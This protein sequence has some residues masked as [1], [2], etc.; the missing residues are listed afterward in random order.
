MMKQFFSLFTLFM[1]LSL[2]FAQGQVVI[3]EVQY[4]GTDQIEL[5]NTGSSMVDVSNW[6]LCYRFVY[7]Q[8]SAAN[9]TVTGN[10]L[11]QPGDIITISGTGLSLDNVSSDLGIYNSSSFGSSTAMQDFVQWG[12]GG[13]GREPV[14]V[15][16]GIW[17]AGDFVPTVSGSNSSIEWDGLGDG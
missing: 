8:L 3:N 5:K 14:A 7:R 15:A 6:W 13:I 2:P 9:I 4:V 11:M 16:K 10:T 1:L 12:A 17:T